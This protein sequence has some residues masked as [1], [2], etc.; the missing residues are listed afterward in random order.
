MR[1]DPVNNGRIFLNDPVV[2]DFTQDVDLDSA[3]L[4]TV[5]FL[6]LDQLG[7]PI[8]ELVSGTFD[9]GTRSGDEAKGRRLT[10]TPHFATN[11]TYDDGGFRA[12]RTYTVQL[13]GG[14]SLNGTALRDIRGKALATPS[15]FSFSTVEGSSPAQ[16]FRN[17][18][19]GGPRR[20]PVDGLTIST[21]SGL[22][23]VP[24]NLFGTPPTEIRLNFD[25]ALNPH[26]GNVP[27]HFDTDP[28]MRQQAER[29][30]IFLEYDDPISGPNTWIPADVELERNNLVGATIVLRPVGVLPN[31]AEIR[32][33]VE[34]ELE[35]I[36]GESNV[37]NLSYNRTF[38]TFTTS[39]SYTQQFNGIADSFVT[40]AQ[41]DAGAVFPEPQ[42]E[43][44]PGYIKAGFAFE[45]NNTTLEFEPNILEV[46]LNTSFTQVAPK[47]GQ[48]FNVS[49]GV[50]N[51]K[52]VHI[53][54]GVLVQGTGPNP[55]VWLCT[56]DFIV[57]G[58]LSVDGG[59]GARV[60]TL[61]SANFAKAGGVGVCGGGNGG[62]GT[63]S[64]N[65]RDQRGGTG[66]GPLQVP[67][68]GGGGGRLACTNGCYTG[69]GYN[70]SGGG[71][72]GGGGTLATQGDPNYDTTNYTGTQFRQKYGEG[73]Y[74]C[75]GA[76][77]RPATLPGGAAG[78]LVF[79]DSRQDNNFWGSGISMNPNRRVRIT[80]EMTIPM[81]GGG[82]GGGGDTSHN[83]VCG[84]D[85]SFANDYSGGGG[86]GGAGALIIKALG[87]IEITSTGMITA[88][89]GNGG[90]GEQVGACGEAG[91]GGA[92][93]G[94]MVVLMSADKIVIHPHHNANRYTFR[95]DTTHSNNNNTNKNYDFCISA[96][97]GV[98]TT[99]GFGGPPVSKKY[100]NSGANVMAGATYDS[101]PLG[102]LGGMGIVQLM[103]PPG[104]DSDGTGT[105][106]DDN[107][108]VVLP[109]TPPAGIN[110]R[111][112]LGWRGIPNEQGT[113]YFDDYGNVI[114]SSF[115]EG[116]IRP[117]PTL[118]PVPFNA[119][120]RARS[121]WIDT[122]ASKRRLVATE[123]GPR[124]ILDNGT[125]V[126]G[127]VFEFAGLDLATYP[128][129]I[130]YESIGGGSAITLPYPTPVTAT[131][132][133]S[134][135]GN[136]TYLGEPAY[137][138]QLASPA[139]G[140]DP[141]R[142]AQYEAEL[143][144]VTGA[145]IGSMRILSHDEDTLLL[146]GDGSLLPSGIT[147]VQVRAK[148]FKITTSGAEGLGPLHASG[149]A[150]P[151][152]NVRIGF[153]FSQDPQNANARYPVAGSGRE[154]LYDMED[155]GLQ[156]WIQTNGAPAFVQWDVTFD[157]DFSGFHSPNPD[158]PRPILEYLRIPFRF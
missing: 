130:Y 53:P 128:G 66:N 11:N 101:N 12:G 139:L 21:V 126:S 136:T 99:G 106:L 3:T 140:S 22:T 158:S 38:G 92:G 26:D 123:S 86:G 16:L 150:T 134:V 73:G 24:L 102:A 30:R 39:P 119:K 60:D 63:P 48:P 14:T 79:T 50:F 1:T 72:G 28:I 111:T 78:A 153:A 154:F 84:N 144:N 15:T 25:Q 49:G 46:V 157:M 83:R 47:T 121:K 149:P 133:A 152:A 18:I 117:A 97:G 81:G 113:T 94:G 52:N 29:G 64:G 132:V 13:V 37:G 34:A 88:N 4:N 96:D 33:I 9:L 109:A 51:F 58:H 68:L 76:S 54:Q 62:Q 100:P 146:A 110:K 155:A 55:M 87:K 90:G 91:G 135:K 147:Q 148:F 137:E 120:S 156:N 107:I 85:P 95:G 70:G 103:A 75:S 127:P 44:G 116:D 31:N 89:G 114:P 17:P 142:Y 129:Y 5:S 145:T 77:P 108:E 42:A 71:S 93:A 23:D 80:G 59:R 61:N 35:D 82:G 98:C 2:I 7:Q 112:I 131:D 122:G 118:L 151:I 104:D 40:S 8:S 56:G 69:S 67:G 143:L 45:G 57:D 27:V 115:G 138:I 43:V 41:I 20:I 65:S 124:A 6:V 36:S 125:N 141:D 32:V 105:I 74:G 19:A 10:F